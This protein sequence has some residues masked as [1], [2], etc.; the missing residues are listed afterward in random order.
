LLP[1]PFAARGTIAERIFTPLIQKIE[2]EGGKII[3]NR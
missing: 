3:G 1:V 2:A